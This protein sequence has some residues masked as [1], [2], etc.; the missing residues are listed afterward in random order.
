MRAFEVEEPLFVN[1]APRFDFSAAHHGR[2]FRSDQVVVRRDVA[3]LEHV[4]HERLDGRNRAAAGDRYRG[5]PERR[6]IA[7]RCQCPYR[8]FGDFQQFEAVHHDRVRRPQIPD[9][10]RVL[11]ALPD[12][13][14]RHRLE[15]LLQERRDLAALRI[16]HGTQ[17][18]FLAP[19]A[20]REQAHADLHQ[21]D[22]T[23]QRSDRAVA[24]HDELA[25]AAER[26]AV[27]CRD[28]RR[29]RILQALGRLLELLDQPLDLGELSRHQRIGHVQR[30]G[31]LEHGGLRRA[32]EAPEKLPRRGGL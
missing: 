16:R 31:G 29:H 20:G 28:R 19:A 13:G 24:V 7:S 14:H 22:V 25:A 30:M 3:A 12:L 23:L 4:H 18:E 17:R 9:L 5:R 21:P 6:S 27:D 2:D 26:K 8:R 15:V 11:R 1:Q 10:A 32:R